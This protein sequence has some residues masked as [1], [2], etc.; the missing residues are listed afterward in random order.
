M[1]ECP[2]CD[3]Q[4]VIC[5]AEVRKIDLIIY[6][7]DECDTVWLNGDEMKEENCI[8]FDSFMHQHGLSPLWD[9]FACVEKSWRKE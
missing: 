5:Q 2:F 3:G 8:A 7:C 6:I 4:G 1:I 9:E